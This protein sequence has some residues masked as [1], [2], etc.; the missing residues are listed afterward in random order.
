MPWFVH[1]KSNV[2]FHL[3]SPRCVIQNLFL[4]IGTPLISDHPQESDTFLM[5]RGY[6][7]TSIAIHLSPLNNTESIID[8]TRALSGPMKS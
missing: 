1:S 6:Q 7:L 3:L 2:T 5:Q 8:S 4:E